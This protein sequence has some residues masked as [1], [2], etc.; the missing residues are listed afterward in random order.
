MLENRMAY[1]EPEITSDLVALA[2][3]PSI[4]FGQGGTGISFKT[5]KF[6]KAA[7]QVVGPA[8]G[9]APSFP[10]LSA[11]QQTGIINEVTLLAT[12]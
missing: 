2:A 9:A 4:E 10:Y 3:N 6:L 5:R 11:G 1:I 8:Y 12:S 7:R